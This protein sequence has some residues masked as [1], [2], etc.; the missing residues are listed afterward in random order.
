MP[1]SFL[2]F[3]SRCDSRF[4]PIPS[5]NQLRF[6][7]L[8]TQTQ[9]KFVF[10]SFAYTLPTMYL[11]Y[12]LIVFMHLQL[13]AYFTHH[14][15]KF[16]TNET[17]ARFTA[18]RNPTNDARGQL[19]FLKYSRSGDRNDPLN[20]KAKLESTWRAPPP[21][22]VL[23]PDDLFLL[24][25]RTQRRTWTVSCIYTYT[26]IYARSSSRPALFPSNRAED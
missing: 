7:F 22:F 15:H 12:I 16:S 20:W 14:Y 21:S 26:Y 4:N 5:N 18:S 25:K 24:K 3:E 8:E 10:N 17:V 19:D 1:F 11:L 23:P 2:L 13:Y 9:D 6:L